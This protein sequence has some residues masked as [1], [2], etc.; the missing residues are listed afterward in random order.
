M[1]YIKMKDRDLI[2]RTK[3]GHPVLDVIEA[4]GTPG[5][6]NYSITHLLNVYVQTNGPV[7]YALL[8]ELVGVL[9]SCK[10]EFYRRMVS[11]Y[12]DTKIEENGDVF[13]TDLVFNPTHGVG[14]K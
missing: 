3:D 2:L 1:P 4:C 8:N 7:R 12:E 10:L 11:L 13:R 14:D 5:T 6:L 9:E